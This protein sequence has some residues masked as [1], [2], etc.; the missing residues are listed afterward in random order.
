MV[1]NYADEADVPSEPAPPLIEIKPEP[2]EIDEG[3]TAKFIVNVSGYPRPRVTWWINGSLVAGVSIDHKD[4]RIEL[5]FPIISIK[6]INLIFLN[7]S[8]IETIIFI[9]IFFLPGKQI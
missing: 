8:T 4:N 1:G 6:I 2:V 9:T 3:E 5:C 7:I